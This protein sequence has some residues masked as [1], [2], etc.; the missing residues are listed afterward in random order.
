MKLDGTFLLNEDVVLRI[1]QLLDTEF[2]I[3]GHEY[4]TRTQKVYLINIRKKRT[5]SGIQAYVR[6]LLVIKQNDSTDGET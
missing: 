3:F 2:N 6:E 1:R 4:N 5:S